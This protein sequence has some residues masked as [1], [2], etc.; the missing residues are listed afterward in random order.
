MSFA[1]GLARTE[2]PR[3]ILGAVLSVLVPGAG[4]VVLGYSRLAWIVA[5][6]SLA[7]W[8]GVIAAALAVQTTAFLLLGGIFI[9][10][11]AV[12]VVSIFALPPGPRLKDGLRALWPV[13]VLF[14]VF[15]GAFYLVGIYALSNH[16]ATDG[17]MGPAIASGDLVLVRPSGEV[18]VGE[19][20]LVE[21]P[22]GS[23]T[24][25]LRRVLSRPSEGQAGREGR[26]LVG[27]DEA[28]DPAAASPAGPVAPAQLRGRALFVFM[29]GRGTDGRGRIWKPLARAR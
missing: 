15:R 7:L 14:P 23:G 20:A 21:H 25:W 29:A 10:G 11:T 2:L 24:L 16:V 12:S 26:I 22:A 6:S 27:V 13:L 1:E 8:G 17:A 19:V 9:V 4:H 5:G 18:A 3:R 28:S